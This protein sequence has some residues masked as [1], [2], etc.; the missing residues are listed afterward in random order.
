MKI[1][2]IFSTSIFIAL[3]DKLSGIPSTDES[4]IREYNIVE[5]EKDTQVCNI[6]FERPL[7]HR[8]ISGTGNFVDF[9]EN[10]KIWVDK[11]LLAEKIANAADRV[12]LFTAPR[13][14]GK[15]L[16]LNMLRYIFEDSS[17]GAS[18]EA[19]FVRHFFKEKV[20]HNEKNGGSLSCTPL[21]SQ[22]TDFMEEYFQKYPVI[23]LDFQGMTLD[24]WR[25]HFK[26]CVSEV[27]Q[28]HKY[29]RKHWYRVASN[30]SESFTVQR[31]AQEMSEKFHKYMFQKFDDDDTLQSS[32][33]WLCQHLFEVYGKRCFVLIDEFDALQNYIIFDNAVCNETG[34]NAIQFMRNFIST[35]KN[36]SCVEKA[37]LTG[38][39]RLAKATL[40]G[41]LN[42]VLEYSDVNLANMWQ[43]TPFYGFTPH[44]V[45]MIIRQEKPDSFQ[46]YLSQ[47]TTWY[48]GYGSLC[49][50]NGST[51]NP[52]TIMRYIE[53]FEIKPYWEET[54]SIY[55]LNKL[56]SYDFF[57]EIIYNVL[58][59]NVGY[60]ISSTSLQKMD[61]H[62]L[63]EIQGLLINAE[64]AAWYEYT[65]CK[66]GKLIADTI[67]SL[68]CQAGYLTVP[69]NL[70]ITSLREINAGSK[71]VPIVIPNLQLRDVWQGVRIDS[72]R[73]R[74]RLGY[75]D[76][77]L[78]GVNAFTFWFGLD[79]DESEKMIG[80]A[81]KDF[82]SK[83]N[84]LFEYCAL[85]ANLKLDKFS[86]MTVEELR[87]RYL[88]LDE[89]A[90]R[91]TIAPILEEFR[92]RMKIPVIEKY[93]KVPYGGLDTQV[94]QDDKLL[95]IEYK[96][97]ESCSLNAVL[98]QAIKR[99][100]IAWAQFPFQTYKWVKFLAINVYPLANSDDIKLEVNYTGMNWQDFI[101]Y[102]RRQN[103]NIPSK[104]K[105]H[106]AQ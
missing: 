106:L 22:R 68:L 76:S 60:N 102:E 75:H 18:P 96:S 49:L 89:A 50:W 98:E 43:F 52:W 58:N 94:L 17:K 66:G 97:D 5:F 42:N 85:F 73:T 53:L 70:N 83:L 80:D 71:Q 32:I 25:G 55:T 30:Q 33:E 90:V 65:R 19:D 79:V 13:K 2:L 6:K 8:K 86:K 14:W 101:G 38:I 45:E 24:T 21:I 41:G 100:S 4:Y 72:I 63:K 47:A 99:S 40:S 3:I 57:E 61:E 31:V 16:N 81:I 93:R 78:A 26:R 56:L 54:G 46:H 11:S 20:I 67:V 48:D 9:V 12:I 23:D 62:I 44:E 91:R 77:V 103:E 92:A 1:V 84:D 95:I 29:L 36:P 10:S 51:F 37:V 7:L 74:C 82:E 64:S 39:I 27:Y 28:K 35:L 88:H 34:T 105:K 15:S 69:S 59:S 87:R 104:G